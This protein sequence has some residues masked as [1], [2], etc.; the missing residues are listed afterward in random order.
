MFI[1][2]TIRSFLGREQI[3]TD[4][5]NLILFNTNYKWFIKKFNDS[6]KYNKIIELFDNFNA[7][8]RFVKILIDTN[9]NNDDYYTIIMK[10]PSNKD[11]HK[12]DGTTITN[13][14][15]ALT[16]INELPKYI[17]LV[18]IY[19][20]TVKNNND[21]DIVITD[22]M[23]SFNE[24]VIKNQLERSTKIII[25][26]GGDKT[27]LKYIYN[28]INSIDSENIFDKLYAFSKNNNNTYTNPGYRYLSTKISIS[29]HKIEI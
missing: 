3:V 19:T 25:A 4:I 23:F 5:S 18:N 14:I 7:T 10:N 6:D 1:V 2:N 11:K 29:L 15:S 22:E 21:S 16:K 8:N 9:S 17:S 13:I 20:N 12:I 28:L 24:S 27:D 26:N